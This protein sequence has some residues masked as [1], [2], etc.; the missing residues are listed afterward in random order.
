MP[1][2]F[3]G[4]I[5]SKH[6]DNRYTAARAIAKLPEGLQSGSYLLGNPSLN[7]GDVVEEGFHATTGTT[8]P[9]ASAVKLLWYR[10]RKPDWPER[11]VYA[12]I[13]DQ[14]RFVTD[15]LET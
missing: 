12:E 9:L 13:D 6:A 7:V 10:V 11:G 3:L 15:H 1:Y 2:K 4:T 14:G 5:P 8:N